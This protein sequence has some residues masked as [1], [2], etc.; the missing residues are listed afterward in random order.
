MGKEGLPNRSEESSA[1]CITAPLE[2]G[3]EC[4][5]QPF[6]AADFTVAGLFARARALVGEKWARV[7]FDSKYYFPTT[8][9]FDDPEVYDEEWSWKVLAF[10]VGEE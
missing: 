3:R 4:T 10:E 5:V 7:A 8:V 2:F 6:E 9:G 1:T